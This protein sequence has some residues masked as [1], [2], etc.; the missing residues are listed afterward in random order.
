VEAGKSIRPNPMT[1]T[2]VT[3]ADSAATPKSFKLLT[4][5]ALSLATATLMVQTAHPDDAVINHPEHALPA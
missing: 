1:T 2:K 5:S 3:V 4:N